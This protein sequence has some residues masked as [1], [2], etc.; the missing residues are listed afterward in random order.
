MLWKGYLRRGIG[1]EQQQYYAQA[2]ID[3]QISLMFKDYEPAKQ[4]LERCDQKINEE[5]D[6]RISDQDEFFG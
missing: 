4:C 1:Y 5:A 6:K 3:I 2:K